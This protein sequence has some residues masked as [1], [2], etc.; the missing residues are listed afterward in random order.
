MKT[1]KQVTL[2]FNG[3][4]FPNTTLFDGYTEEMQRYFKWYHEKH[5][6]IYDKF[7]KCARVMKDRGRKQYGSMAIM[8]RLDGTWITST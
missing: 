3:K 6:V 7:K 8:N 5:P 4:A 1:P 2:N